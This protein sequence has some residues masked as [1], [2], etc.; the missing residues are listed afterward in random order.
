MGEELYKNL[1][2]QKYFFNKTEF[3]IDVLNYLC[4]NMGKARQLASL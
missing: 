2:K 3:L 4:Y 1:E